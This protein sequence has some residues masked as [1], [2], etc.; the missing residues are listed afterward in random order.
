MGSVTIKNTVAV[1][2]TRAAAR[3]TT[4]YNTGDV[5]LRQAAAALRAGGLVAFPTETVYGLGALGLDGACI[6][7][8]YA[9]KGRPCNNPVILHT[10]TPSQ[11]LDLVRLPDE[12]SRRRF[13]QLA[14]RFWPGPLTLVCR[15]ADPVPQEATAGLPKVAVRVPKHP[16]ANRLLRL[17]GAP[18]A[19]PS[20]NTSTRPSAT[21]PAHVLATLANKIDGIVCGGSCE[22]GM[23]ST[24]VDIS[25]EQPIVLRPGA[26]PLRRL[27]DVLPTVRQRDAARPAAA[28]PSPGMLG[29]HYAPAIPCI[30]L[31]DRAR[32]Q[33]A[34][35]TDTALLLTATTARAL[36][37]ALGPDR[38]GPTEILP[39]EQAAYAQGMYAALYRLEQSRPGSLFIEQPPTTEGRDTGLQ[40]AILDRLRRACL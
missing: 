34:W 31:A 15:K 5:D 12:E 33:H 37:R 7:R 8:L 30:R 39:D 2:R 14:K 40:T 25:E 26:I 21:C 4:R 9:A 18:L 28:L 17:V 24:V 36:R 13:D 10:A 32:L 20:A 27:R 16:V 19:A 29:R 3:T 22:G 23:E 1:G 6:K 35:D 38:P 11:A